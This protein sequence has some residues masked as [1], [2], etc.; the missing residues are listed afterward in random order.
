MD[1]PFPSSLYSGAHCSP[2]Q[3]GAKKS[4]L[5]FDRFQP[6]LRRR[7]GLAVMMTGLSGGLQ[8]SAQSPA[9]SQPSKPDA[10]AVTD[11]VQRA[12]DAMIKPLNPDEG[13]VFFDPPERTGKMVGTQEETYRYREVVREVPVYEYTNREVMVRQEGSSESEGGLVKKTIRVRGK[14]IGTKPQTFQVRDPNGPLTRTRKRPVFEKTGPDYWRIG[15][16]ASNAMMAVALLRVNDAEYRET[17]RPIVD[18]MTYR[19]DTF[20][21]PEATI[22]LAWMLILFVEFDEQETQEQVPELIRRLVVSQTDSGPGKGL[23]GPVAV[24]R[25]EVALWMKETAERTRAY[26]KLKDAGGS[27]PSAIK[28]LNEAQTRLTEANDAYLKA[29][30]A[31]TKANPRDIRFV[32][33]TESGE[34]LSWSVPDE[35][36][37]NQQTSDL[38]STWTALMALRVARDHRVLPGEVD[39]MVPGPGRQGGIATESVSVVNAVHEAA[40]AIVSRQ[41]RSG[42]FPEMNLHQPVHVFEN[43]EGVTGV[44]I[45]EA[46]FVELEQPLSLISTAQGLSALDQVAG[47]LGLGAMRPYA[48]AMVRAKSLLDRQIESVVGGNYDNLGDH[49]LKLFSFYLALKDNGPPMKPAPRDLLSDAVGHLLSLQQKEGVWRR[50]FGKDAWWP[51]VWRA[52]AKVLPELPKNYILHTDKAF[53]RVSL[54]E[55]GVGDFRVGK[56]LTHAFP[57]MSTAAAVLVLQH[58]LDEQAAQAT[59][60]SR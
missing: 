17:V 3:P 37:F 14:Q 5:T 34:T 6:V 42:A 31:F 2:H 23:W 47:I 29:A 11:A 30:G 19:T 46:S 12:I 8:V 22:D 60:T 55:N 57:V 33:E 56:T 25:R 15:E 53:V 54:K 20:G 58:Y 9:V 52:R 48:T 13:R 39:M 10:A 1:T 27:N 28:R 44:P 4:N 51:T 38:E 41:H 40:R 16:T 7:V 35:Y 18:G 36:I 24:N 26:Q 50:P 45:E 32:T 43:M 59:S 21:P 49:S